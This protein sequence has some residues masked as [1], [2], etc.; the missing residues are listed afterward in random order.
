[1]I[2]LEKIKYFFL[3]ILIIALGTQFIYILSEELMFT[4][5]QKIIVISTQMISIVGF[6][7][8]HIYKREKSQ[9]YQSIYRAHVIVFMIYILNLG[10]VLLFDP[11][12]GRNAQHLIGFDLINLEFMRTIR[13]FVHGYQ[14]GILSL[15]SILINIIGN[16]IIF[17]PMAYFLPVFFRIQR[18][19]F[20]FFITISFLVA[21][22]ELL[23]MIL[24]TGSADIDDWFLNVFGAI[25]F[26]SILM[27]TPLK[28]LYG[29]L[30]RKEE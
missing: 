29:L 23:Q 18:K 28:K 6:T 26:Y 20:V 8:F 13:I 9:Q 7:F 4:V 5:L 17:M 30:E 1:M 12:F 14:L 22:V 15:E 10:Y 25:S 16:L 11:D 3:L 24:Q 2:K 19:W 21:G 27:V